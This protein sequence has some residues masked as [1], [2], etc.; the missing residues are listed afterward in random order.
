MRIKTVILIAVAM[1]FTAVSGGTAQAFPAFPN[2]S[3]IFQNVSGT[4]T[5]LSGVAKK[6]RVTFVTSATPVER[7]SDINGTDKGVL[8]QSTS[9]NFWQF[10]DTIVFSD[11]GDRM[12]IDGFLLPSLN[13]KAATGSAA[14]T[15]TAL[16]VDP[17][18]QLKITGAAVVRLIENRRGTRASVKVFN[19]QPSQVTLTT[20]SGTTTISSVHGDAILNLV[21]MMKT[22]TP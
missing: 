16:A 20:F 3:S 17:P 21:P 6:L 5:N 10:A 2:N 8:F 19:I 1:V 14:F 13:G 11:T 4:F 22:L 18:R 7:F 15:F 12:D 9:D